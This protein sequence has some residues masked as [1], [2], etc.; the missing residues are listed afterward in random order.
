MSR[1]GV[2]LQALKSAEQLRAEILYFE[3]QLG[4]TVN[5]DRYKRAARALETRRQA[6]K[7]VEQ[8]KP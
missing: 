4:R 7:L 2:A 1:N 5:M 3:T 8:R 6:L